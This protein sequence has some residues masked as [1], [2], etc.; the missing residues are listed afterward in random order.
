MLDSMKKPIQ[1]M[2]FGCT[3]VGDAGCI[4]IVAEIIQTHAT[5]CSVVV[6]VS[7][8]S[9]VT[10][11]LLEAANQSKSGDCHAVAAIFKQLQRRHEEAVTVLI[12]SAEHRNSL[13]RRLGDLFLEG[14]RLCEAVIQLG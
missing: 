13:Q 14:E 5:E 9:G 10:N 6:V 8:M 2:K 12:K 1:V 7:A 11:Q 4:A 3:S